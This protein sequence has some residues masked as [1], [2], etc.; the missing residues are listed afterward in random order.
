MVVTEK[1]E[2]R[3]ILGST[4][5][6]NFKMRLKFINSRETVESLLSASPVEVETGISPWTCHLLAVHSFRCRYSCLWVFLRLV[7]KVQNKASA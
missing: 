1:V 7:T 5:L 4:E 3:Y 6:Q 2:T